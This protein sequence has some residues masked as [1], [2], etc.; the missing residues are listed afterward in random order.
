MKLPS[1]PLLSAQAEALY[2]IAL[3]NAPHGRD[4]SARLA[5]PCFIVAPLEL[6][7][8][9]GPQKRDGISEDAPW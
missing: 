3:L 9:M 7:T 5:S 2:D 4:F 6:G 8:G 1:M